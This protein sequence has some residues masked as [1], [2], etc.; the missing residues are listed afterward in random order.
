MNLETI[1][2]LSI[3]LFL[4]SFSY[5]LKNNDEFPLLVIIFFAATG[6]NRYHSVLIGDVNWIKVSYAYSIFS[7]DDALALEALNL[8]LLGSFFLIISYFFIIKTIDL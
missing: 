7:L 8:F 6:L 1:I 4:I 3:F 2:L 5:F